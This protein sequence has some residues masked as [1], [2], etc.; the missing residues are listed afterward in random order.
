MKNVF[1]L[2]IFIIA[3]TAEAYASDGRPTLYIP[4]KITTKAE[5]PKIGDIAVIKTPFIEYE[6]VTKKLSEISLGLSLRPKAH[7]EMRGEEILA[8]INR[9][10]IPLEAFGYSIPVTVTIEREGVTLSK[11]EVTES[12]REELANNPTLDVQLK[13]IEWQTEQV[14]PAKPTK[15]QAEILGSAVKGKMPV[16]ISV[17]NDSEL[18]SRFLATALVDD[19]KSVPI[20]RGRLDKGSVIRNEDIQI[21][22]ANLATLPQDVSFSIDEVIGRRALRGIGSGEAIRKSDID[23]P[24]VIEK[25]KVVDMI[26]NSGGFTAR[27]TGIALQDG[28]EGEKIELKNDRSHKVV[29]GKIMNPNEVLIEE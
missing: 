18:S 20:V 5:S 11:E 25:G 3:C 23:M 27:A 8:I 17:F 10:G 6:E 13:G 14:L 29:K 9:E 28:G 22:R 21:V 7:N 16:R 24:P 4:S 19:W 12:L 15:I 1:I 26:Y 2:L